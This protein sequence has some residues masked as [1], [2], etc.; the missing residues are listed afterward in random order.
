MRINDLSHCVDFF[1]YCDLSILLQ[2]EENSH[3][4]LPALQQPR[5]LAFVAVL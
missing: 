4:Q 3:Y 5:D 1:K 2:R